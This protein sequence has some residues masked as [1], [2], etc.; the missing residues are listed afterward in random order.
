MP[1]N[2]NGQYFLPDGNPVRPGEVIKSEWANYTLEDV[3]AAVT[4]SLDRDGLGGMRQP[5][6]N[7]DGRAT[8]PG[9]TFT[10]EPSTGFYRQTTNVMSVAVNAKKI[11]DFSP[12]GF[13]MAVG[14]KLFLSDEPS[15]DNEAATKKYVDNLATQVTEVIGAFGEIKTPADLPPDGRIPANWDGLGKPRFPIQI[16][17][18]QCLIYTKTD[19]CWLFTGSNF[20][21]GGWSN[22]GKIQ[23]PQ[24][25]RGE[26][27]DQGDVGPQGP[28]GP[29][30]PQGD[31]GPV[32]PEGPQGNEGPGGPMGPEGRQG[33]PGETT[34]LIGTFGVVKTPA[35]LPADGLLPKDWDGIG[36]PPYDYQMKKGESLVYTPPIKTTPGYG[37]V[38]VYIGADLIPTGWGDAGD[39]VGPAGPQGPQGEPGKEGPR[40]PQGDPGKNGADGGQGPKG[41]KGDKGDPGERGPKGDPG[42]PNTLAIGTVTS[43]STP[44]VLISGSS[45]NQVLSFI[46]QQGPRGDKGDKGDKG[47]PGTI[48]VSSF[49]G[50]SGTVTL[51]SKDVTGALGYTPYNSTNPSSY[52]TLAAVAAQGY[53]T[54]SWVQQQGYATQTWVNSQGFTKAS[55]A[56]TWSARQ[57]FGNGLLWGPTHN[58][59]ANT[60][61]YLDPSY[62]NSIT[63]ASNGSPVGSWKQDKSYTIS[64]EGYK[65]GGG[66]WAGASDKRLKKNVK[67]IDNGLGL[68]N[69]LIPVEYEWQ[70]N[71]SMLGEETMPLK[72]G[73]IAQQVAEVLP[74]AVSEFLPMGEDLE[75]FAPYIGEDGKILTVGFK[76]DFFAYLVAAVQD[77]QRRYDP[78]LKAM[79]ASGELKG[80][81]TAEA[82]DPQ[83]KV[84]AVT[85]QRAI[86]SL[87]DNSY[88]HQPEVFDQL[89]PESAKSVKAQLKQ[90]LQIIAK[91]QAAV[92]KGEAFTAEIPRLIVKFKG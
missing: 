58:F 30:G 91:A 50:R 28:L 22:L 88:L 21:P 47:D 70:V 19:E 34:V 26:K 44:Q 62:P 36:N 52:T 63:A 18:G 42:V 56:Y 65:P 4:N 8:N 38:Y 48:G 17:F 71:P 86:K 69:R 80:V 57:T 87:R 54:Q 3:A 83:V 14:A 76:M 35:D 7:A 29:E 32:G 45:P 90:T 85:M 6:K 81:L 89:T 2:A 67:G 39:I 82:S 43:G 9:M 27:G 73:F 78:V 66:V 10:N 33:P 79:E 92:V 5:L 41:D 24:G 16:N 1:R 13:T 55:V 31:I 84:S 12:N 60:S 64:G 46:L 11:A 59:N 40:G 72:V 53:T 37:H 74:S 75:K 68:I 49:N 20:A 61:F 51:S 77:L 23:G 15:Y 25:L